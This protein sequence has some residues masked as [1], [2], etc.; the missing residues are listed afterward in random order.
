M[1]FLSK[2]DMLGTDRL[3]KRPTIMQVNHQQ[4]GDAGGARHASEHGFVA[5]VDGLVKDAMRKR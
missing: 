1:V 2:E 4:T 3:P 5:N